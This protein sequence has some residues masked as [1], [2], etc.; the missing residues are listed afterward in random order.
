MTTAQLTE[1]VRLPRSTVIDR[2][3]VLQSTGAV[4][5]R[6]MAWRTPQRAAFSQIQKPDLDAI[7]A[8]VFDHA[9]ALDD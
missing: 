9:A 4:E 7:A 1:F 6:G 3:D 5:R 2:L 8:T